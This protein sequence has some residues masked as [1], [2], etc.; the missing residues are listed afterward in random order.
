MRTRQLRAGSARSGAEA[1]RE[2]RVRGVVTGS[3]ERGRGPRST[4]FR[5][6]TFITMTRWRGWLKIFID[7]VYV[8][9]PNALHAQ[10]VIAAA[11]A[12]KHV[13]CEKPMAVSVAECDAMLTA[14]RANDV[15]LSIGY[16]LQ[17]DPIMRS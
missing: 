16:R 1:H 3:P 2:L 9:T 5:R 11:G 17:F 14:C 10:H 15:K 12:K 7:I 13:I 8:V 6:K 4:A